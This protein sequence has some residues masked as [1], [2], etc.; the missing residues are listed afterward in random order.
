MGSSF[1]KKERK[2]MELFTK[3]KCYATLSRRIF[4]S[5]LFM[6]ARGIQN[7][8][9]TGQKAN[10]TLKKD[11][12]DCFGKHGLKLKVRWRG[13]GG[14]GRGCVSW[15][16]CTVSHLTFL[17]QAAGRDKR[18]RGDKRRGGYTGGGGGGQR[19]YQCLFCKR[20][21]ST[22]AFLLSKLIDASVG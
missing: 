2:N 21:T 15:Q 9:L 14:R 4:V 18:S 8:L 3:Y 17:L 12:N 19:T 22:C 10:K 16:T 7:L 13:G 6:K 20:G 1:E 11:E 5:H